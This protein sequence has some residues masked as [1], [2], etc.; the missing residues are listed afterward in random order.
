MNENIIYDSEKFK[1]MIH[2]IIGRC[3]SK[4]NF[5]GV[6]LY[7][8]LYF[9]DFDCYEKYEEPISGETYIRKRNGLV[10]FHF[11][12]AFNEL[13]GEGKIGENSERTISHFKYRYSSLAEPG[14]N[15]LSSREIQVI[16]DA[17]NRISHFYSEEI[18][19][20]S[21]GEIPWR[22]ANDGEELNYEAVFYRNSEYSV[23][24]YDC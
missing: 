6:V 8:L 20:Y 15:L 5:T 19:C 13:I 22:L 3:A 12:D 21:H 24:D 9:S 4:D 18:S 7:N 23:R 17:I 10:P 1:V 2:Y 16:D 14:I 11:S